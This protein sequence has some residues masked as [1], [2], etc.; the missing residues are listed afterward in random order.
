MPIP[1][2]PFVQ[3]VSESPTPHAVASNPSAYVPTY[4]QRELKH[5]GYQEVPGRTVNDTRALRDESW[6]YSRCDGLRSMAD[7]VTLVSVLA[8]R[9]LI[10]EVIRTH[11]TPNN[12]QDLPTTPASDLTTPIEIFYINK[13]PQADIWRYSTSEEVDDFLQAGNFTLPLI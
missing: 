9:L 1:E 13:S 2:I 7:D 5:E 4:V 10:D 8:T 6:E 11:S 12:S 3:P